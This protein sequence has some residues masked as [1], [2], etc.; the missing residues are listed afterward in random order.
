MSAFTSIIIII[1]V[2]GIVIFRLWYNS[3]KQKGKR[4]EKKV[5]NILSHLSE[6]YHV[7]DDV[8]LKTQRGTTQIDHI[9]ISKYGVFAIET[10]NY[11]GDIYGDD[12]RE[13]WTQ[14]IATEVTYSKKWYKTYTYITK[15]QLYNPVKQSFGHIYVLKKILSEWKHIKY[16]PIVVFTGNANLSNVMSSIDV[17][18][19]SDLITTILRYQTECLSHEDV[20]AVI[21]RI[22]EQNVREIVDDGV[23]AL[24]VNTA[25][26]QTQQ[27]IESGICPRC[28]G[29]LILRSG[30][31]SRFYGCSNYPRCRFTTH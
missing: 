7:L 14:I 25:K 19:D 15:N 5:H 30:R 10:K 12:N 4:G 23:H 6:E 9:V 20:Y 11:R 13:Q 24:N 3:P 28:G 2:L 26:K 31:Y 17:V 8:V 29:T 22:L 16:I 21:N 1:L 27:K 18:F